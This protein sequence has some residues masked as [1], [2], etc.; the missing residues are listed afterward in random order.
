MIS[1]RKET[2]SEPHNHHY[3]LSEA[4]SR[5]QR[6]EVDPNQSMMVFLSL[7]DRNWNS[8]PLNELKFVEMRTRG[9][10]IVQRKKSAKES[11]SFSPN[12]KL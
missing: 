6:R 5:L 10:G 2:P 4:V 12:I 7:G 8:G 9:K 3:F 1:E 11:F